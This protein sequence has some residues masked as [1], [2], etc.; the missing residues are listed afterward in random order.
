MG[1]VLDTIVQHIRAER[2]RRPAS[3]VIFDLDGTLVDSEPLSAVAWRQVLALH[4]YDVSQAA[5][6]AAQGL[7]FAESY[8]KL[9]LAAPLPPLDVVWS[10][11]SQLLY[12]SYDAGLAVFDDAVGAARRL[13]ADGVALAVATS[14][15]RERLNRTLAAVDLDELFAV[16]VAGDEV[17]RGK[18]APD[19]YLTA[20]RLLGVEPTRCVAVEDSQAGIDAARTAGMP[21]LAVSRPGLLSPLSGA[22][23]LTDAVTVASITRL[24]GG[25]ARASRTC[26]AQR[27]RGDDVSDEN[28]HKARASGGHNG[29]NLARPDCNANA[30]VNVSQLLAADPE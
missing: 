15:Q 6:R 1:S 22:D 2:D 23:L 11:Y 7:R 3:A 26:R 12:A 20:A 19:G 21:V 13:Q 16:T 9:A 29:V 17:A 25:T 14:S 28:I 5:I 10:D 4:G 8:A 18:P 30:S 27:A 24:L